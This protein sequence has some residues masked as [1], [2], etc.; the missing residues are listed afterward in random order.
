M[1]LLLKIFLTSAFIILITEI[2]RRSTLIEGLL[3]SIPLTSLLAIVWIYIDR[4]DL[5]EIN[6]L[7]NNILIMIPPSLA[8]FALLPFLLK[9]KFAFYP[10]LFTSIIATAVV[11]FL[12]IYFLGLFEIRL[13]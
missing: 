4:K 7:S 11:Y 8:F 6:H 5:E 3:A 9:L 10:S 12:Y 13:K 1:H 2:S